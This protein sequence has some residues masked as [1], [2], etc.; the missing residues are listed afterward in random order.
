MQI[1]FIQ[2]LLN[3]FLNN[4]FQTYNYNLRAMFKSKD[5]MRYYAFVAP[6]IKTP[7][8]YFKKD[9]NK[10]FEIKYIK[11]YHPSDVTIQK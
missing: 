8:R 10:I 6:K 5:F 7:Q 3:A 2:L 9:S 4:T 1:F 11:G